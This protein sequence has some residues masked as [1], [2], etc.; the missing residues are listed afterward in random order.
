M[1][2]SYSQ[3]V[4]C[5]HPSHCLRQRRRHNPIE[6]HD[7]TIVTQNTL[8]RARMNGTEIV[9]KPTDRRSEIT[10]LHHV[11]G[12]NHGCLTV[13]IWMIARKKYFIKAWRIS[14]PRILKN[15]V[16]MVT[17]LY[18]EVKAR[19]TSEL[20]GAISDALTTNVWFSRTTMSYITVTDHFITERWT[21]EE[22]A[23]E[24]HHVP[25]SHTATNFGDALYSTP[26][27]RAIIRVHGIHT[28]VTDNATTSLQR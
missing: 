16:T 23:F 7:V 25:A 12:R 24:T 27:R 15:N 6:L 3:W 21:L 9:L 20:E 14:L 17:G 10:L 19:V 1:H 4:E 11:Q 5:T 22:H 2:K 18:E 28:V 26:E 8:L 13:F